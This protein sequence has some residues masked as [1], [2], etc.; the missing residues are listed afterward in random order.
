MAFLERRVSSVK[1]EMPETQGF[2]DSLEL[3]AKGALRVMM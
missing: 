3:K 1:E 2:M